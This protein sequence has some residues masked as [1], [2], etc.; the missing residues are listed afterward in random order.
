[1]RFLLLSTPKL[2]SPRPSGQL[3]QVYFQ[4]ITLLSFVQYST[5]WCRS[6]TFDLFQPGIIEWFCPESGGQY[7]AE[8]FFWVSVVTSARLWWFLGLQWQ[9]KKETSFVNLIALTWAISTQTHP[10][11]F[12]S[13]FFFF[14][15]FFQVKT[16]STYS[17]DKLQFLLSV[18]APILECYYVVACHIEM[19][20]NNPMTGTVKSKIFSSSSRSFVQHFTGN[21]RG[22]SHHVVHCRG[23]VH[24][25]GSRGH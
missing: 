8:T 20:V 5:A 25:D 7:W 19:L 21:L 12:S 1:M 22:H 23:C 15:F 10:F 9:T 6:N 11:R 16:D 24:E 18:L 2:F 3:A 13:S 17:M 4:T 14:F